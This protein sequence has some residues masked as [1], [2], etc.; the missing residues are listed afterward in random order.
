MEGIVGTLEF[1]A[2]VIVLGV[3]IIGIVYLMKK[4]TIGNNF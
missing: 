3:L 4:G 1:Y 2:P